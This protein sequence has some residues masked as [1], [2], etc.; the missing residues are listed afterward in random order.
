MAV[1]FSKT[2]D[3]RDWAIGN[4]GIKKW[5]WI[6]S[7]APALSQKYAFIDVESWSQTL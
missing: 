7:L 3:K 2:S 6:A 1:F 4:H 5:F